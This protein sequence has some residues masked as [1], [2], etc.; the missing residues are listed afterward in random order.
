MTPMRKA[1]AVLAVA[2]LGLWGCAEGP[3]SRQASL[4]R[5]RALESRNAK[6]EE[7]YRTAN[8][9]RDQLKKKLTVVE[10]DQAQLQQELDQLKAAARERDLL[11]QEAVRLKSAVKERD[12]LRQEVK[13]RVGER[14]AL[15]NQF[16]TFRKSIREL[17]GQVD[18]AAAVNGNQPAASASPV[19]SP[20]G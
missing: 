6:L 15:Q 8:A 20:K 12:E 17:L 4:E 14:E 16:E 3:A 2:T 19:L 9:L 7:D 13:V 18:A 10:A 5:T 11:R 1:L